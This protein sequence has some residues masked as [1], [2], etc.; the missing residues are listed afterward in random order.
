MYQGLVVAVV[1]VA[2]SV[3]ETGVLV[4]GVSVTLVC[5]VEIA[6]DCGNE[7]LQGAV[8]V[9][10]LEEMNLSVLVLV[11]VLGLRVEFGVLGSV[12]VE[13]LVEV[14]VWVDTVGV[15]GAVVVFVVGVDGEV[16]VVD[17]VLRVVGDLVGVDM[18][19]GDDVLDGRGLV[20]VDT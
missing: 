17:E 5:V 1:E 16:I 4:L 15:V 8:V 6:C 11:E 7:V 2:G 3:V 19:V 9:L 20:G 12:V 18:L 13:F 14:L 10:V